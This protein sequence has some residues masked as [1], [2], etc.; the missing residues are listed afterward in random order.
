MKYDAFSYVTHTGQSGCQFSK[1]CH[2]R[3]IRAW[4]CFGQAFQPHRTFTIT[5][6]SSY[7]RSWA[8]ARTCSITP[9][10]FESSTTI[11]NQHGRYPSQR[12]NLSFQQCMCFLGCRMGELSEQSN[13]GRREAFRRRNI[14]STSGFPECH[15]MGWGTKGGRMWAG[16][17]PNTIIQHDITNTSFVRQQ[18]NCF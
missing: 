7:Q 1:R 9:I 2:L 12:R 15:T 4:V 5:D 16:Q 14:F 8:R 17:P 10:S 6:T 11:L 18:T 13:S 3:G